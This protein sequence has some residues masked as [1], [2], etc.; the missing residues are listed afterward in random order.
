MPGYTNAVTTPN[1]G[2]VGFE[3]IIDG[4]SSTAMFSEKLIRLNGYIV[5]PPVQLNGKRVSYQSSLS[6][7]WDQGLAEVRQPWRFIRAARRPGAQ[8]TSPTQWTGACWNGSH[9][10]TLHF[11]AYNHFADPNQLSCVSANSWGGPPGGF[12]DTITATS[13]HTGGVNV[14]MA[15]GSVKFIKDSINPQTWWA[16]G[17]RNQSEVI[18]GDAF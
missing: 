15:D 14:C 16:V 2:T 4:L 12:N 6:V 5:V 13:N 8:P 17:S 18:S 9:A 11:N 10:G 1:M 3:S 7:A